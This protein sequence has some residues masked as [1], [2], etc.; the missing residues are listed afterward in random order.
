[1]VEQTS[2]YAYHADKNT[3][4]TPGNEWRCLKVTCAWIIEEAA[5]CCLEEF[6]NPYSGI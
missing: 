3:I 6:E 4:V 5:R 1:M 2:I